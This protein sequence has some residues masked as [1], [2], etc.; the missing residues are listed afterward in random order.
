MVF[1]MDK[2]GIILEVV[3]RT[4]SV[5]VLFGHNVAPISRFKGGGDNSAPILKSYSHMKFAFSSF[6]KSTRS[7][8]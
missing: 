6:W 7:E 5:L 1:R 4:L 8:T 2:Y 3:I